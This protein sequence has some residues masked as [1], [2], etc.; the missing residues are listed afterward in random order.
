MNRHGLLRRRRNQDQFDHLAKIPLLRTIVSHKSS[1][2][3]NWG[4]CDHHAHE[5][6]FQELQAVILSNGNSET[7]CPHELETLHETFVRDVIDA[8]LLEFRLSQEIASE[9]EFSAILRLSQQEETNSAVGVGYFRWMEAA[10]LE[11]FLV[12]MSAKQ[13]QPSAAAVPVLLSWIDE[14]SETAKC[15]ARRQQILRPLMTWWSPSHFAEVSSVLDQVAKD[16][17]SIAITGNHVLVLDSESRRFFDGRRLW[18]LRFGEKMVST[19]HLGTE[20]VM[21]N[22]GWPISNG[23]FLMWTTTSCSSLLLLS[24]PMSI[25]QILTRNKKIGGCDATFWWSWSTEDG[26]IYFQDIVE[27]LIELD[28]GSP[29]TMDASMHRIFADCS[30]RD[31]LLRKL[32]AKIAAEEKS[33]VTGGSLQKRRCVLFIKNRL[34]RRRVVHWVVRQFSCPT[35]KHRTWK[36]RFYW[37]RKKCFV[38]WSGYLRDSRWKMPRIVIHFVTSLLLFIVSHCKHLCV[39]KRSLPIK[40]L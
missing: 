5:L 34:E 19:V 2:W 9:E 13:A 20:S 36:I 28:E 14:K 29:R 11:G 25:R 26:G 37:I 40:H 21:K 16:L 4:L 27:L 31:L 6:A 17:P 8:K 18:W 12:L 3:S 24:K 32:R 15:A 10:S 30:R 39:W 35:M 38:I 22:L 7:S 1:S 23:F 33:D